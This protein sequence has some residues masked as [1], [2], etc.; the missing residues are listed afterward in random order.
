MTTIKIK[1]FNWR[2]T[3]QTAAELERLRC[4]EGHRSWDALFQALIRSHEGA[5]RK[6]TAPPPDNK[7]A[8]PWA[9]KIIAQ[10]AELLA[11]DV[12]RTETVQTLQAGQEQLASLFRQ[13]QSLLELVMGVAK[14]RFEEKPEEERTPEDIQR[15]EIFAAVR[16]HRLEE[17]AARHQKRG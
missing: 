8:P 5:E 13:I 6:E 15:D 17:Y 14:E 9:A 1:R 11:A 10:Q 12:I 2:V 4:R 7:E 3:E 16:E